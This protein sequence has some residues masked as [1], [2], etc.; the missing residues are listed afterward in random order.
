M[1]KYVLIYVY[2]NAVLACRQRANLPEAR[3]VP[4]CQQLASLLV[5]LQ[6][7]LLE[8]PQPEALHVSLQ[9]GDGIHGL[10][11]THQPLLARSPAQACE[12]GLQEGQAHARAPE[13]EEG[14]RRGSGWPRAA[15]K[16]SCMIEPPKELQG[17]AQ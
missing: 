11:V 2:R 3:L 14:F 17:G 1:S 6:G 12:P 10:E 7:L 8:A 9:L 4:F 13:G 5:H 16:G 15:G